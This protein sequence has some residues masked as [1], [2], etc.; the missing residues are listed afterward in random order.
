M[1]RIINY[2]HLKDIGFYELWFAL[3]SILV[4][5]KYS[6]PIFALM[7]VIM[8]LWGFIKS[9][10]RIYFPKPLFW[11]TIYVVIH[12][13]ILRILLKRV[14]EYFDSNLLSYI[15]VLSSIPFI[16][17]ALNYRKLVGSLNWVA[18]I[19]MIGLVYQY[20]IMMAGGEVHPIKLPF[21][22]EM[23]ETSRLYSVIMRP[24]SFFWEPQSYCSFMLVPQFIAFSEKKIAWASIITLSM[25]LSGS[26]TGI[27]TS[28][29]IFLLY[30]LSGELSKKVRKRL[31]FVAIA[32]GFFFLSSSLFD[33]G[34]DK[35]ENVDYEKTSRLYN[36]PV[37]VAHMPH[38]DLMFGGIAASVPD[39][40]FE[41]KA[42]GAR[43]LEKADYVYVSTIWLAIVK[44]GIVGL[45]LYLAIY[46]FPMADNK[47]IRYYLIPL[48][49]TLFSNPDF[50]GPIFAFE[51]IF[52]YSYI[53][54]E[55]NIYESTYANNSIRQ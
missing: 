5:Y 51:F 15:I 45:L 47:R 14:P 1:R 21:M 12:E 38:S 6:F 19:C 53:K 49:T 25:L 31:A 29:V 43:L 9:K 3:Y 36:G 28:V 34:R 22:P 4:G 27:I 18:I 16:T 42:P 33:K 30:M 32:I 46:L 13:V 35:M 23:D 55:N 39:Y 2:F 10:K 41:G 40:Y 26:T 20:I 54:Q 44:F 24:S 17:T 50:I 48:I 8:A 37:L 7:L 11:L 52:I